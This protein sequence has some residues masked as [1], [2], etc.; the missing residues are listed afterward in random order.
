MSP[1]VLKGLAVILIFM[2]RAIFGQHF[3]PPIFSPC[4]FPVPKDHEVRLRILFLKKPKVKISF[5]T[6][7]RK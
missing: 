3:S 7:A 5:A 1:E 2:T 4:Q 6:L